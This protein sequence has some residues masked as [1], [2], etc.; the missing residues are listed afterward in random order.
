MSD[1]YYIIILFFL[2]FYIYNNEPRTAINETILY[3]RWLKVL[4]YW[5]WLQNKSVCENTFSILSYQCNEHIFYWFHLV[6]GFHRVENWAQYLFHFI[7]R[8]LRPSW[9]EL[10]N[11]SLVY[12]GMDQC[13][14]KKISK[15]FGVSMFG[16]WIRNILGGYLIT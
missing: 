8:D 1:I 9:C 3:S 7:C 16:I 10:G 14:I 4:K 11:G 6:S 2:R 15:R 5:N 12:V 13:R